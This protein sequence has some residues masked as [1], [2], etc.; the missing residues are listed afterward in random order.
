MSK[1]FQLLTVSREFFLLLQAVVRSRKLNLHLPI[2]R[3]GIERMHS[4]RSR[5]GT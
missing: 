4:H 3:F 2:G 1:I 5:S